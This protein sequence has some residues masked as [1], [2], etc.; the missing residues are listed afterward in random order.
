MSVTQKKYVKE[1]N[2]YLLNTYFLPFIF[3]WLSV[4][5][6]IPSLTDKELKAERVETV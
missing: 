2:Q 4:H 1:K 6:I 5:G 3:S